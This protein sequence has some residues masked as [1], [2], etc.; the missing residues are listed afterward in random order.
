MEE[1][2]KAYEDYIKLLDEE[3]NELVGVA[4]VHGWRSSR[5]EQGKKLREEI[6]KAKQNVGR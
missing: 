2:I 3:L 4:Y 5:A 6:I 1:L